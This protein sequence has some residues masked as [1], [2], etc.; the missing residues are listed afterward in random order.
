MAVGSWASAGRKAAVSLGLFM[1][2]S[3][4]LAGSPAPQVLTST[5]T[6]ASRQDIPL[7]L[8]FIQNRQDRRL[9]LGY[10]LRWD[11]DD[12]MNAGPG[13]LQT[14]SDPASVWRDQSWDIRD[15][16]RLVLYGVR[17]DPWKAFFEPAPPVLVSVSSGAPSGVSGGAMQ[18]RRFRPSLWP[19][20]RDINDH[21]ED[22]IRGAALR[23]TLRRLPPEA[24]K[25]T[26]DDE[27]DLLRDIIRWQRE[28][29]FPGMAE[30]ADGLEYVVPE[31]RSDAARRADVSLSTGSA[32]R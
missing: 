5:S 23:E 17:V 9:E 32:R 6:Q 29:D 24:Q 1:L 28:Y 31:R 26:V 21:I 19:M 20:I 12:L 30:A 18:G 7:S 8:T 22:D 2:S 27:K 10:S 16:T 15:R 14:L 3:Q 25:K 11:F 4:A 13:L